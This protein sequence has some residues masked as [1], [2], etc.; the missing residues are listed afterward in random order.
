[1]IDN[2][3]FSRSCAAAL[4]FE[5]YDIHTVTD[6][7]CIHEKLDS[8]EFGLIITSYPYGKAFFEEIKKK[9]I[10]TIILSDHVNGE[11]I[12]ILEK[13]DNCYCM[14]KPVDYEKLRSLV[15]QMMNGD[16]IDIQGGYNIV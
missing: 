16:L 3:E 9:S 7:G 2:P 12:S 8:G 14:I 10:A 4:E 5:G 13:F 1:M 11:L 6:S 15:R